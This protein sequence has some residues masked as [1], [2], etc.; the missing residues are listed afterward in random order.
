VK[1]PDAKTHP[2]ILPYHELPLEQRLKDS[3]FM[4]IVHALHDMYL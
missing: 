4:A 2:C 3:L 1:D